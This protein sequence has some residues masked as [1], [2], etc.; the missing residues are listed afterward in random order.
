MQAS[1]HDIKE[2]LATF[3]FLP[4][5]GPVQQVVDRMHGDRARYAEVLKRVPVSID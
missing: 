3:G 4:S 1:R 2:K 5:P